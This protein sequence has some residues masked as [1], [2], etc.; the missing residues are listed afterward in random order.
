VICWED[1]LEQVEP[2]AEERGAY[3]LAKG[4]RTP[5]S[6]IESVAAARRW[7]D[8]WRGGLLH[9]CDFDL[10]FYGPWVRE[11]I[12]QLSSDSVILVDPSAALVDPYILDRMIAHSQEHPNIEIC[13]TQAAPGLGGAL[14]RP[15]LVERL[16]AARTHPGRLLHY[17][18]DQPMRDPLSGD[19]CIPVATPVARTTRSFRLDSERQ[20]QR[21]TDAATHLN[22][23][24]VATDAEDL[25][26]RL[27][28]TPEVDSLPREVVLELNTNRNTS[29]IFWP[30]R[31]H[32]IQRP[33]MTIDLAR[34]IFEQLAA[35]QDVRLTLAGV[36][37]PALHPQVVEIIELADSSGIRAIHLE[38]DLLLVTA[39]IQ[40]LAESDVDVISVQLPGMSPVTYAE[41]MGVDRFAQVIENIRIFV[42]ARQRCCRATPLMAPIFVKCTT[43]VAEMEIWYD[44]WLKA[45]GGAVIDGPSDFGG[46]IPDCAVADMS[47]PKRR[48]CGR[49]WSRMTIHSDGKVVS[50]EQD[51]LG[52][53]VVGDTSMQPIE[54][55][56]RKGFAEL[57]RGHKSEDWSANPVCAACREWHRP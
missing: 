9:T 46:L 7:A 32:S 38:T 31:F 34:R 23:E 24:L 56:W 13:F 43:N 48:P 57:R 55:I 45:V 2:I 25:L 16:A 19:G 26:H 42:S 54:E 14:L 37:D 27:N 30:G 5:M 49:L 29:P 10:G 17:L 15:A 18:P 50:C 3:V 28:W 47:P 6:A 35:G 41:V 8:G 40:R 21:M 52:R 33:A 53:Q 22:G 4:P 11:V 1:Q 39:V 44:Q 51:V 36:G 20:I 12:E